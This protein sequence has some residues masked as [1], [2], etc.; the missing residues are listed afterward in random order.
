MIYKIVV[1]S[2]ENDLIIDIKLKKN[3]SDIRIAKMLKNYAKLT[4]CKKCKKELMW[5]TIREGDLCLDCFNKKE[6]KLKSSEEGK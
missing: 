6:Q 5:W 4:T 2:I 3:V 1:S